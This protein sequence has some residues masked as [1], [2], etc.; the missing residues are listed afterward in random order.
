MKEG[1]KLLKGGTFEKALLKFQ[2]AQIAAREYDTDSKEADEVFRSLQKQRDDAIKSQK[3][4]ESQ[5]K[6]AEEQKKIADTALAIVERGKQKTQAALNK[7][8]KLISAFYFYDDKL[9]LLNRYG[10]YPKEKDIG[11]LSSVLLI[12]KEMQL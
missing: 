8:N 9:K 10:S 3:E 6:I 2:A 12:R 5:K 4:A 1:R 7:A 11:S